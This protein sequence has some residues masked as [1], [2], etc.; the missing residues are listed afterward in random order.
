MLL[1]IGFCVIAA[2]AWVG[3]TGVWRQNGEMVIGTI[4]VAAV[5]IHVISFILQ[6]LG[7]IDHSSYGVM[8]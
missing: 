6:A 4:T 7:I 1:V 5:V 2:L 8:P 3:T